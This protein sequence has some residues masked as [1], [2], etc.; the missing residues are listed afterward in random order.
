MNITYQFVLQFTLQFLATW[1]I[2]SIMIYALFRALK[3]QV[4]WKPIFVAAGFAI[5]VMVI[6]AVVNIAAAA[7][8]PNLYFSFDAALGVM[9]NSFGAIYYPSQFLL[10]VAASAAQIS[11]ITAS[12]ATFNAIVT[13]MF[14]ISYVWLGALMGIAVK[15]MKPEFSFAKCLMIA[16]LSVAITLLIL[17]LFIGF[18]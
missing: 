18:V 1:L 6:R 13:A 4:L 12:M 7:T 11:S 8:L 17:W 16:A 5:V 3:A 15:E 9:Y 10:P 14:V 2:L